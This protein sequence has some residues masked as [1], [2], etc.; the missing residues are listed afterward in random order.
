M[1]KDRPNIT[2]IIDGVIDV[3]TFLYAQHTNQTADKLKF[4]STSTNATMVEVQI[5]RDLKLANK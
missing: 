2:R 1:D 3:Y 4:R 5:K